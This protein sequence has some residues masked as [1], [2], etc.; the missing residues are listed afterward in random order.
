MHIQIDQPFD[1]ESTLACGQG[2]RWL[3]I[4]DDEWYEGVIGDSLIYI[5]QISEG[6]E[7]RTTA[8]KAEIVRQLRCH[9]RLE[10][11]EDD[12]EVIYDNLS[13]CDPQ[14]AML[15]R[16]FRGLRVMRIDPWECL[17]FFILTANAEIDQAKQNMERIAGEF[18]T[19]PPLDGYNGTRY[20]FPKPS[21]LCGR[22]VLEKLESLRLGLEDKA[23]RINEAAFAVRSRQLD[24]NALRNE[25]D[26]QKVIGKLKQLYNRHYSDA[27]KTVNCV[28]LFALDNLDGFPIDTHIIKA[29]NRLYGTE[30]SYPRHKTPATVGRWKWC[31]EKFGPYAGYA[32]QFLFIDS[33][34][35]PFANPASSSR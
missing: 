6:L 11:D 18:R 22:G 4:G 8:D 1:L 26:V 27:G 30:P 13:K 23:P 10:D 35:H 19:S 33:F 14:M 15:V 3:S 25:P 20:A 16:K 2:H 9:F 29:L 21:D 34:F 24:L 28:A 32:S 12:I 5:R 31:R 7:F 17:V